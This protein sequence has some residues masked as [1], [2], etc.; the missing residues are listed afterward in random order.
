M[1][2]K[3]GFEIPPNILPFLLHEEIDNSTQQPSLLK[4]NI[5]FIVTIIVATSLRFAVRFR[6]LRSAGLDDSE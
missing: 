1:S 6:M 3:A 4:V 2:V 5:V